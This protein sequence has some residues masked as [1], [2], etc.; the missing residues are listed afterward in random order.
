MDAAAK[1]NAD[2]QAL[3]KQF[4]DD[5]MDKEALMDKAPFVRPPMVVPEPRKKEPKATK[6]K[7]ASRA[8][9]DHEGSLRWPRKW[10]RPRR[11]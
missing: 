5:L 1:R 9:Q 7:K 10:L 11:E 2:D 4:R 3:P 8:F 6:D